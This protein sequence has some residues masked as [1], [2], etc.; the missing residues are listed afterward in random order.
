MYCGHVQCVICVFD[1][2]L[3]AVINYGS[4]IFLD[5][6]SGK[7][8]L[9]FVGDRREWE[10]VCMVVCKNRRDKMFM[11]RRLMRHK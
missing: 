5:W 3:T 8:G 4:P 11:L 9:D 1:Y 2:C 10:V 6:N 7:R